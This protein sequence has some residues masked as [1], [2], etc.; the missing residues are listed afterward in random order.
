[1]TSARCDRSLHQ[2]LLKW[3]AAN[4]RS[5]PWRGISDPYRIWVSEVMLQQTQV[6]RVAAYYLR[7]LAKFPTVA[8]LAEA[9]LDHVLAEWQ[10]L[11]YYRRAQHLHAAAQSLIANYGGELPQDFPSLL[12]LPGFGPYTAGAVASIAFAVS[13]PAVDGAVGRVI[14]RLSGTTA[15]RNTSAFTRTIARQAE[16]LVPRH[17]AGEWNQA[18]MDLAAS[19]CRPTEP[20]CDK[21][22]LTADCSA[23][24]SGRAHTLPV[25][26]LRL[27]P[28][29]VR[30]AAAHLQRGTSIVLGQRPLKGLFG[31]LWELPTWTIDGTVRATLLAKLG[32]SARV[33]E[34]LGIASRTLTHRRLKTE[35]FRVE[36][37][38]ALPR[39]LPGYETHRF[40]T[41]AKLRAL[42]MSSASRAAL[43]V[44][45]TSPLKAP[46]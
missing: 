28:K 37:L 42:P 38:S 29:T 6:A 13:V 12:A 19:V 46:M 30:L 3:Y 17:G 36:L 10:G 8:S 2:T 25:L 40:F 5:F 14:A 21:C 32:K 31:G 24:R 22:P 34:R 1:M 39:K 9:P 11:G 4:R 16:A 44:A 33:G 26:G 18:L 15:R 7:F 23:Y 27:S 43:A 20:L 35:V 41:P 45:S